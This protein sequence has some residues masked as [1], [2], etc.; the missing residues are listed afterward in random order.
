MTGVLDRL[1][2][3]SRGF[4][5]R[6][7]V[8]E[9]AERVPSDL[10]L[11]AEQLEAIGQAET[12][13]LTQAFLFPPVE[14]QMVHTEALIENMAARPLAGLDVDNQ[15]T[16]PWVQDLCA[17]KATRPENRPENGYLLFYSP[18]GID[19]D[20]KGLTALEL[21][22]YLK[23]AKRRSMTVPEYLVLQRRSAEIHKDHRFDAYGGNEQSQWMCLLDHRVGDHVAMAYWTPGRQQ[24]VQI[25][26]CALAEGYPN[27][28]AHT[29]VVVPV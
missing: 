7:G 9:L 15:Y 6:H 24:Q 23:G 8:P 17:L 16:Q 26:L 18:T 12:D 22:I 19:S 21:S 1:I 20:T 3:E 11:T 4:F 29:T 28:G 10:A 13:G 25:G 2:D 5:I 27:M 14:D